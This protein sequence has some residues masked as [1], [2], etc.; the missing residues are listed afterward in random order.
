[1]PGGKALNRL[2]SRIGKVWVKTTFKIFLPNLPVEKS[3]TQMKGK[4]LFL[5]VAA[6]V[7]VILVVIMKESFSQPGVQDLEG[8]FKRR[9]FYKNE[10]NTGPVQ[11]AYVVSTADTLWQEMKRYGDFMPHTKYGTTRVYFFHHSSPLPAKLTAGNENLPKEYRKYCLARYEKNS[12]GQV[13]FLKYP[14]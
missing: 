2:F 12:M 1:M 9:A 10:N 11:R 8:N 7:A 5:G 3:H 4:K 13:S 6:V 14:F